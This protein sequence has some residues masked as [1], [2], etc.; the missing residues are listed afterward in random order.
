MAILGLQLG[1][2][3]FALVMAMASAYVSDCT[4]EK[5]RAV[6]IGRIHGAMF[7]GISVGPLLSSWLSTV[8]GRRGSLLVFYMC[9]TMRTI[10]LAYLRLVPESLPRETL[11]FR[12]LVGTFLRTKPVERPTTTLL[13]EHCKRMSPFSWIDRLVPLAYP[14]SIS[15]RSNVILLLAINIV[16]YGGVLGSMDVLILYP[17]MLY[18]W[19]NVENNLF[20]SLVNAFRAAV[21]TLALPVMVKTFRNDVHSTTSYPEYTRTP[22]GAQP[23]DRALIRTAVLLELAG[24]V[25]YAVA[26]NGIVFTLCGALAAFGGIGL[27]TTEAAL[28]K[29][30]NSERIGELMGGLG[31]LQALMRIVAPTVVNLVYAATVEVMPQ[32]AFLGIAMLLGFGALLT[33]FLK[34]SV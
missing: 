34:V 28:T 15:L 26:P 9:L 6:Q 21:S 3:S 22:V 23:L 31:F 2:G 16:V 5:Q 10:S 30:I 14:N 12:Q 7:I 29:H 19:G 13:S 20:M 27:A 4:S 1:C 17:Q 32:I 25:G 11:S 8:G 33:L 18:K 24:Y